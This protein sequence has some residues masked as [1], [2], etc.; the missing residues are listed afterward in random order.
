MW[1]SNTIYRKRGG[2]MAKLTS[3]QK[4]FC[5]E[6][7]IDL[8][9]TQAAIRAGYKTKYPDKIGSELL[10]KTR[11][12][13]YIQKRMKDREQRTEITQDFVLNELYAIAAAKGPDYMKIVEK[14]VLVNG[15]PVVD[16]DGNSRTYKDVELEL[17]NNLTENSKKAIAGIKYGTNGIEVKLNDKV[18]ALELL[19]KHLGMFKDKVEHS[20]AIANEINI[21]I[22][23]EDYGD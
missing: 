9:A 8:N 11:V 12:K 17:T 7:L 2:I 19:G 18:K 23:G 6:Y 15:I 10:G 3:K 5:D 22:D 4:I 21:T 16:N 14:P 13:E 20:G 1:T